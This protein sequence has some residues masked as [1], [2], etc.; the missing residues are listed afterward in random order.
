MDSLIEE[1]KSKK[2]T[3]N[4]NYTQG[5][6]GKSITTLSSLKKKRKQSVCDN[7][8]DHSINGS[9]NKSGNKHKVDSNY[10]YMSQFSKN[11][12]INSVT[13][14]DTNVI[15]K[16][17]QSN[18][19]SIIS[20]LNELKLSHR[21]KEREIREYKDYQEYIDYKEKTQ[22]KDKEAILNMTNS[23]SYES[24][25]THFDPN[26]D[27]L[28][29]AMILRPLANYRNEEDNYNYSCLAL[30]ET[31]IPGETENDYYGELQHR[32]TDM[33]NPLYFETQRMLNP[34]M[35]TV[36]LDWMMDLCTQLGFKRATFHLACALVDVSLS[37]L[38]PINPKWL[39]LLGV[40]C[41]EIAAKSEEI[42]SP[43]L[44]MFA[45]ATCHAY[46]TQEIIMFEQKILSLLS[47]KVNFP[48]LATWANLISSKWDSWLRIKMNSNNSERYRSMPFF[49]MNLMND[50]LFQRFFYCIDMAILNVET[51]SFDGCK[52]LSAILY[53][54]IGIFS[55]MIPSENVIA[56]AQ[57][58]KNLSS[59]DE[60]YVLNS[61]IDMFLNECMGSSLHDIADYIPT[62]CYYISLTGFR[63]DT[64]PR[65]I[66]SSR[67]SLLIIYLN[68]RT[69]WKNTFK[70]KHTLPS[71]Y[72][73]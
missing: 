10:A 8:Q 61:T 4:L 45:Y 51:L 32:L 59:L 28:G 53:I 38:E 71:I 27:L 25:K 7:L 30:K 47:W 41:L 29:V 15:S 66:E 44:Q 36:L 31:Y 72:Q 67:V 19:S 12:N 63:A 14:K 13:T 11:E 24:N 62:S 48:T 43:P 17:K 9:K 39:Q 68:Y 16:V 2:S 5:V 1:E 34:W 57:L 21:K 64:C 60:Y 52:F 70:L 33:L 23:T 22:S 18:G 49:R 20:N 65:P 40:S 50:Y 35:R 69:L 54:T 6:S 73:F 3:S 56:I 37:K 55:G 46:S 42:C 26:C 58:E